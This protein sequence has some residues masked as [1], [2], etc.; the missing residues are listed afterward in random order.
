MPRKWEPPAGFHLIATLIVFIASLAWRIRRGTTTNTP[1][2]PAMAVFASIRCRLRQRSRALSSH[3]M[4]AI[5]S[6][7]TKETL[8]SRLTRELTRMRLHG[9]LAR[10]QQRRPLDADARRMEQLTDLS[11]SDQAKEDS[12]GKEGC[13]WVRHRAHGRTPGSKSQSGANEGQG[14]RRR[15]DYEPAASNRRLCDGWTGGHDAGGGPQL[16]DRG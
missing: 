10:S 15:V 11:V 9:R 6:L 12:V 2:G 4:C 14:V 5:I 1:R 13:R 16:L 3:S 8:C 7:L